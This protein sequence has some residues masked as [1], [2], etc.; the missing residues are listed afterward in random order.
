[1]TETT[2]H[3]SCSRLSHMDSWSDDDKY[4]QRLK[5][6]MPRSLWKPA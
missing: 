4:A 1:M 3:G 2:P 6:G 5:Q